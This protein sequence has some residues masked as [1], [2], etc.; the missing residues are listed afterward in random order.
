[1]RII[2]SIHWWLEAWRGSKSLRNF[3]CRATGHRGVVWY[4]HGDEPDMHCK[5]CG[6]NLA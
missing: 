3:W 4:S 5:N 2:Y 1:M 6:E